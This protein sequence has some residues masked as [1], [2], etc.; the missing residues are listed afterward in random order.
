MT[1]ISV[2]L[3]PRSYQHLDN[4]CSRLQQSFPFLDTVNIPDLLRMPIH[5][6]EACRYTG[7]YFQR[8]IPHLRA[9]DFNLDHPEFLESAIAGFHEVLVVSG[10]PPQGFSRSIYSTTCLDLIRYIRR[11]HPDK[12]IIAGLDPY[13]Q[14]LQKELDYTQQKV[15]AGAS[16]FFTQPLFSLKLL[17]AFYEILSGL[18]VYWGVSPVIGEKSKNYWQHTNLV[19]FP[20]GYA[21]TLEGNQ[22]FARRVM[23]F[24]SENDTN[25]YFMPIRIDTVEY[26]DGIL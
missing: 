4:D 6:W 8:N 25:I 9:R 12:K 21:F 24:V 7:R 1:Q 13:R 11:R 22:Q 15:K 5:S 18:E 3:V 26:L 17:K 23:Q 10:D 16:C 14:N 20:P 19:V 2:E